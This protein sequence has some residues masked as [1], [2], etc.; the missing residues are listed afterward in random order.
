MSGTQ[1]PEGTFGD[2]LEVEAAIGGRGYGRAMMRTRRRSEGAGVRG[3]RV[4]PHDDDGKGLP[5]P[6]KQ[7]R[8]LCQVSR[9]SGRVLRATD[10]EARQAATL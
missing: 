1:T 5:L 7:T 9:G 10:A 4:G 3:E 6:A 2:L 8:A